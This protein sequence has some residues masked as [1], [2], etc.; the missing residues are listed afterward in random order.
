MGVVHQRFYDNPDSHHWRKVFAWW[1]VQTI[2]GRWIWLRKVYKQRF[3]AAGSPTGWGGN[4]HIEPVVEYGDLF[5]V[6]KED[7]NE[8]YCN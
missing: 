1:P 3:W 2:S 4:F 6:L 7:H 5:D 8:D